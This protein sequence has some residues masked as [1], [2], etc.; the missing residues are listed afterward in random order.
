MWAVSRGL[1][2]RTDYEQEGVMRLLIGN[3]D[4]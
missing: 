2:T 4:Q 1:S 3:K